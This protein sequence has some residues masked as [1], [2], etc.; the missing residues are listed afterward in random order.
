MIA[1]AC[2][3]DGTTSGLN[4]PVEIKSD[5]CPNFMTGYCQGEA[6]SK[7]VCI[8]WC[9]DK[10]QNNECKDALVKYCSDKKIGDDDA[11]N[12][13]RPQEVYDTYI[14]TIVKDLPDAEASQIRS[15]ISGPPSCFYP[16]CSQSN[17][18]IKVKGL[19]CPSNQIQICL[20]Q[21][22]VNNQGKLQG[23]VNTTSM[24]NCMQRSENVYNPG[25][26]TPSNGGSSVQPTTPPSTS[27]PTNGAVTQPAA[28]PLPPS[29]PSATPAN[30]Q[31]TKLPPANK[32]KAL[33]IVLSIVFFLLSIAAIVVS[34]STISII[35]TIIGFILGA[36]FA[37]LAARS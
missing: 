9:R 26:P 35:I 14:T 6:L 19:S 21:A 11:C 12:C 16:L 23:N 5:T 20:N 22:S 3:D 7:G 32:T 17:T 13:Y 31:G 8:R 28:T 25:S 30:D 27:Q 37:V 1:A 29:D 36:V 10:A 18:A 2:A 34:R 4:P 33:Y 15:A 24:I